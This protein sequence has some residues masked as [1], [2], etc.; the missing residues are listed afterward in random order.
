MSASSFQTGLLRH[1]GLQIPHRVDDRRHRQ[2]DDALLRPE[3][4]QLRVAGERPPERRRGG[5]DLVEVAADHQRLEGANR[6]DA[7]FV[8]A[9]DREREAVPLETAVGLKDHVGSGVVGILVNCVRPVASERG[10]KSEI[11]N[12]QS[13]DLH[14][15]IFNRK[16]SGSGRPHAIEGDRNDDDAAGDDLLDP[17][18]QSVLRA[19]DLDHRHDCGADRSCR[20]RCRGRRAGCRR[21]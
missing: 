3:P 13:G 19:A 2:V 8:A 20:R 9:A 5:D 18:G 12:L 21:R 17:V 7:H 10:R 1:L 16:W 6:R 4:A 15:A 11:D 14:S